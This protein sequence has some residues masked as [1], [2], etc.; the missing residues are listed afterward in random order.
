VNQKGVEWLLRAFA[1]LNREAHLDI[2][3]DGPLQGRLEAFARRNGLEGR[4]TFHGWVKG[5]EV[6]ALILR[7]RAVLFPSLWQ[8]P[9]G[10]V[11][12]ESAAYGRAVIA[13]AVGGIPEYALD[14]FARS[15][16]PNDT[17]ALV[18][19][20]TDLVDDAE[21][22]EAMGRAGYGLARSRF[23]MKQFLDRLDAL[24]ELALEDRILRT[25]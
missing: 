21:R 19:A 22:A 13:S 14:D 11:T 16:A 12:L 23:S 5:A 15:V 4:I 18:N 7:A 2:A 6:P 1:R 8:E 25:A 10:L 17:D 20:L 24:Y 9:A 3:G